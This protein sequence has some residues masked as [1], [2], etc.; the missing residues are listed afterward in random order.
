MTWIKY[1][2]ISP[3]ETCLVCMKSNENVNIFEQIKG[4]DRYPRHYIQ[5]CTGC[6]AVAE[7]FEDEEPRTYFCEIFQ[8]MD[9]IEEEESGS[10]ENLN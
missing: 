4:G 7:F 9:P 8:M 10:L 2:N 6:G 3:F 1:D 5:K